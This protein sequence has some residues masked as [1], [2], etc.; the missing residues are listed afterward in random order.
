MPNSKKNDNPEKDHA[1]G[2]DRSETRTPSKRPI[3][4]GDRKPAQGTN[5][6]IKDS[7]AEQIVD[8]SFIGKYQI[9]RSIGRGGMGVVYL[10]LNPDT[11]GLVAIKTL[12]DN[13]TQTNLIARFKREAKLAAK[14]NH[15]N[16]V[17]VLDAGYDHKTGKHYIV[18]EYVDGQDLEKIMSVRGGR[19]P[20]SEAIGIIKSVTK[21]LK[22]A[23]RHGIVHRDIKPANVIVASNAVVKLTDLGIAKQMD[24][25][26]KLTIDHQIVGT[27]AYLSP[28]QILSPKDVDTRS[29]IYSLGA[30]F[31]HLLSG[32]Y[33]LC[34]CISL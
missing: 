17:R 13:L 12:P 9:Q 11:E 2:Q 30:T 34:R 8:P 24:V 4:E 19:L 23:A 10:G 16:A 18:T 33:S 14:V 26:S 25:D 6:P 31:F 7:W 21:G 29:D 22:E 27:P 32:N 3:N 1:K 15:P 20:W 5:S 28:E